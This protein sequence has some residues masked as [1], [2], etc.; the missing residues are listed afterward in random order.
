MLTTASN[1]EDPNVRFAI[2]VLSAENDFRADAP[3]SAGYRYLKIDGV[4]PEAGDTSRARRTAANGDYKFHM[5]LKQFVRADYAGQAPK[6][7][8]EAA[9]IGQITENLKNP[10]VESCAVFP[11]GL[12]LNPLNFSALYRLGLKLQK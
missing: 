3:A 9:I 5:E 11:R 6:T 1:S 7:P 12:T 2:G 10:P 4:H 8:F